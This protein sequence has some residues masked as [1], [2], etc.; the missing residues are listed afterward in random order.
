MNKLRNA[1]LAAGTLVA[2]GFIAG[3]CKDS[4]GNGAGS[5]GQAGSTGGGNAGTTGNGGS[6]AGSG[7]SAGSA[8]SGGSG[9]GSGGMAGATPGFMAIA[10]CLNESDYVSNTSTINFGLINGAYTYAPKCLKVTFPRGVLGTAGAPGTNVTFS[11]DFGAHPLMPSTNRGDQTGNPITPT[12]AVPDG[13]TSK[14]FY[15]ST[16]YTAFFAYFCQAHDPNDTGNLM[17]GVVWTVAE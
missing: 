12:S 3:S 14:T 1:L 16:F 15:F 13:G 2:C 9:G 8:G 17:S 10:P 4:S 7:G 11:G 5:P 6:T